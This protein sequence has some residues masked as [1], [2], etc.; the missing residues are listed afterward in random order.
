TAFIWLKQSIAAVGKMA[1]T[2]YFMHSVICIFVFTGVGFGLFGKLQRYELLYVV[3]ATWIFQ[4][5]LSPIWLKYYEYG[6][7]EWIWRNL[8]Y[9]KVYPFR[10]SSKP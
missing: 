10:K 9:Q 8:S 7:L 6:P 4:L 3:F 5:I 2:N 1:L